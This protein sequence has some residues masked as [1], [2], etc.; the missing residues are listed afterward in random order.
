M[1]RLL[2]QQ[3]LPMV[4]HSSTGP[5]HEP[6]AQS[7][8]SRSFSS[9]PTCDSTHTDPRSVSAPMQTQPT[10]MHTPESQPPAAS[11]L[12]PVR[13]HAMRTRSQ[14]NI[15]KPK[16]LFSATKHPL[17]SDIEPSTVSAALSDPR[18]RAAMADKFT[19][20]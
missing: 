12:N 18:W 1:G 15:F 8:S 16:Q 2:L 4:D 13:T 14:N 20:L 17:P 19:A 6:H 7:D 9:A 3:T 5:H 11:N 10:I